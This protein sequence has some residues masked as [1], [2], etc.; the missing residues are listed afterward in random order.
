[1]RAKVGRSYLRSAMD[2]YESIE[3]FTG[4][5]AAEPTP[6]DDIFKQLKVNLSRY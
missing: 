6:E 1:M 4:W 5:D 2:N 3:H